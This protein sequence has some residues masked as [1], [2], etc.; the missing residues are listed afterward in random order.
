[1]PMKR[2]HA[3]ATLIDQV[4][5]VNGWSDTDVVERAR[6]RGH[7]LSKSN[8]SRVRLDDVQSIKG[9][10]IRALADGLGISPNQV[11]AAALASMGLPLYD[12]AGWDTEQAIRRDPA[13]SERSR[14]VL[15]ALLHEL[16]ETAPPDRV[17]ADTDPAATEKDRTA[18]DDELYAAYM[19]GEGGFDAVTERRF[20][21][22]SEAEA[23][24]QDDYDL[25]RRLGQTDLGKAFDAI[26][27]AGEGPDAPGPEGGAWHAR[28]AG[29]R[30]T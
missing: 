18:S 29:Q 27:R 5:A 19:R 11:A 9:D 20:R 25:A 6:K 23:H 21:A 4:R 26:D 28:G 8:V 13:L 10:L 7:Q 16:Q 14:R 30:S 22:R 17:T 24:Q 3:L 2:K 12:V 1:M 15:L